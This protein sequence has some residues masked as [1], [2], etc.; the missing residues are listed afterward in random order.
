MSLRYTYFYHNGTYYQLIVYYLCRM[1][2]NY[3][4]D[5]DK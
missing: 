5:L 2:L 4:K 1:S 3:K